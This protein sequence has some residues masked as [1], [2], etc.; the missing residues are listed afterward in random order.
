MASL[1]LP[2]PLGLAGAEPPQ[3]VSR[4]T[5]P[6]PGA[7]R[8]YALPLCAVFSHTWVTTPWSRWAFGWDREMTCR[9][10]GQMRHERD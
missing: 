6:L 1:N 7:I 9:R 4:H 5:R 2:Q 3:H 8:W 10:C